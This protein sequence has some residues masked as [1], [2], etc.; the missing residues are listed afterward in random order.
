MESH[1]RNLKKDKRCSYTE[2]QEDL[3]RKHSYKCFIAIKNRRLRNVNLLI[4]SEHYNLWGGESNLR[5]LFSTY[6]C[7]YY[8]FNKLRYILLHPWETTEMKSEHRRNKG[9]SK[10]LISCSIHLLFLKFQNV[11]KIRQIKEI[12]TFEFPVAF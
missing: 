11:Y 3:R 9:I 8:H 4:R 7:G 6:V 5:I 12:I 2:S 1:Q 10:L